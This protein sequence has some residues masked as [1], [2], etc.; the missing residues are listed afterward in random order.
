MPD[1]LK[2]MKKALK[3]PDGYKNGEPYDFASKSLEET[4]DAMDDEYQKPNK[5]GF[6]G[7][8]VPSPSGLFDTGMGNS[9]TSKVIKE[10][11]HKHN[12]PHECADCDAVSSQAGNSLLMCSRCRDRKYCSV[13]CQKRHWKIHRKV[14]ELPIA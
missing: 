8:N 4:A 12:K 5:F 14:C 3:G 2:Q 11:R 10:L 6:I 13:E 1:A 9:F 7:M